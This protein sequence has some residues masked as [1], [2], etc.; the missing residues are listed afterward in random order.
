MLIRRS[1]GKPQSRRCG[2]IG[3]GVRPRRSL[4]EAALRQSIGPGVRQHSPTPR[5][6]AANIFA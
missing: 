1:W 4:G 2:D 3:D 5:T 6:V